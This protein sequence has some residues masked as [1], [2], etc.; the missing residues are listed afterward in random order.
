MLT[1]YK[2]CNCRVVT[3]FLMMWCL[4][5]AIKDSPSLPV[6]CCLTPKWYNLLL[7][8][9]KSASVNLICDTTA[10]EKCCLWWMYLCTCL[11]KTLLCHFTFMYIQHSSLIIACCVRVMYPVFHV[12]LWC[13]GPFIDL[14]ACKHDTEWSS[15]AVNW[16][17]TI[18]RSYGSPFM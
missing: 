5:F 11:Y 4:T 12:Q 10:V 15:L 13:M 16:E 6:K 14:L 2:P 8:A 18:N 17:L 7:C 3:C 1:A 9:L